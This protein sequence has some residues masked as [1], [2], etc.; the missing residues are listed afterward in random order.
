[1]LFRVSFLSLWCLHTHTGIL[2]S[3]MSTCPKI[4]VSASERTQMNTKFPKAMLIPEL[5]LFIVN[6]EWHYR[7]LHNLSKAWKRFF[8]N[9][10]FDISLLMMVFHCNKH[11][12]CTTCVWSPLDYFNHKRD[13][14]IPHKARWLSLTFRARKDSVCLLGKRGHNLFKALYFCLLNFLGT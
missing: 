7:P 11:S 3:Q 12:H 4:S 2:T 6:L 13:S 10:T 14:C 5:Y 9:S 8:W 1:M